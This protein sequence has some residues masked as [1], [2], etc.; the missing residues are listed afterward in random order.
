MGLRLTEGLHLQVGDIDGARKLVHVHRGK[1]AKD[2]YVPLPQRTLV[3][4]R[5]YW[6]CHRHP[7]WLFPAVGRSHQQAH[8]ALHPMKAGQWR[9]PQER[10]IW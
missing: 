7:H 8:T 1:G 6:A 5:E 10:P 3:R 4:L 2:R 9:L